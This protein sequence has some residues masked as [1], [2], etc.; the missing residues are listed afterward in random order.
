M[1]MMLLIAGGLMFSSEAVAQMPQTPESVVDF[2][3]SAASALSQAHSI[4]PTVASD[5]GPF[6]DHFDSDMPGFATLRDNV[7]AMV[8]EAAVASSIEIVNDNGDDRTR[9]LELDW[10]LQIEGQ[11]VRREIIKCT[12]EKRKK[13]WKFTS[14]DPIDFFKP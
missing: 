14:L 11:P 3:A 7:E 2:V 13:D 10:N 6:L 9:T 1:G 5:A 8:A 12:I 4:D